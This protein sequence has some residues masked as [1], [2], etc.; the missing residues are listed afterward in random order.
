MATGGKSFKYPYEIKPI[1]RDLPDVITEVTARSGTPNFSAISL[2][3]TIFTKCNVKIKR[4][5]SGKVAINSAIV[6]RLSLG[7]MA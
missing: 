4:S 2:T 1:K 7:A 3:L 6:F 5:S